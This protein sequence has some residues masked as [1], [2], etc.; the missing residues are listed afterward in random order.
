VKRA[1]AGLGA[2]LIAGA[3]TLAP[4][5]ASTTY[6]GAVKFGW[7]ITPSFTAH[8]ASNVKAAQAAFATGTA[9][10]IQ[11]TTTGGGTCA[12]TLGTD[13]FSTY[14]L[15]FG[16][17]SPGTAVTGCNYQNGIGISVL[18]NDTS[19]YTIYETLDSTTAPTNDYGICVF[20]ASAT[21]ATTTT[22]SPNSTAP[23]AGTFTAG[24]LTACG[25]AGK[26][27][28]PASGTVVNPGTAGDAA[29]IT[30]PPTSAYTTTV[31]STGAI[32]TVASPASTTTTYFLGEDV[33][34][35]VDSAAASGT[36]SHA[37]IVYFVPG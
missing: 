16:N 19:G 2:L 30:A 22:T 34:R 3:V 26:L 23:A 29:A 31:P 24:A 36:F 33:Q 12:S 28:G 5:G 7:T 17:I 13:V 1:V 10:A 27:L 35:T 18:T 4:A 14:T 6:E 9:N 32:F 21:P 15:S 37:I 20:P 25:G 8:L 11:T